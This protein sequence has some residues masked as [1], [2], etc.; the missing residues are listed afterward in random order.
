MLLTV[1]KLTCLRLTVDLAIM[2]SLGVNPK[3][4]FSQRRGKHLIQERVT[5]FFQQI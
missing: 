5:V 3:P 1:T 4:T 2:R